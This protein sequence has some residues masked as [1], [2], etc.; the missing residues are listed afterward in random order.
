MEVHDVSGRTRKSLVVFITQQPGS[1]LP[2]MREAVRRRS[3]QEQGL[4]VGE[5]DQR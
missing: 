4:V 1:S 5:A 3:A 2:A